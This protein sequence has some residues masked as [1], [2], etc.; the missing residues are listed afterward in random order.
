MSPEVAL[1]RP[2]NELADVYSFA[3]ILYMIVALE[4]PYQDYSKSV[5]KIKVARGGER[6][7]INCEWPTAIQEL[8]ERAWSPRLSQRPAMTEV[9]A[10]LNQVI[11]ELTRGKVSVSDASTV[12]SSESL[13]QHRMIAPP[14]IAP[15]MLT[16]SFRSPIYKHK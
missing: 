8:L 11:S 1:K 10:V 16:I 2:Y 13:E 14:M 3:H 12:L 4:K 7:P 9:I 15:S 5:H 6:P